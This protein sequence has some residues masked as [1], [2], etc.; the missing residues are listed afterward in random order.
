MKTVEEY[1]KEGVPLM[2]D[3]KLEEAEKLFQMAIETDPNDYDGW[4]HLSL[5]LF[6]NR[7]FTEAIDARTK[8]Q[9]LIE[10]LDSESE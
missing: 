5:V 2:M 4:F 7:Q 10:K 1:V 6:I 9:E 8:A 3:G